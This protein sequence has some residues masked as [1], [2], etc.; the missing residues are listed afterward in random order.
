MVQRSHFHTFLFI[1]KT[2]FFFFFF[3][4]VCS[5]HGLALKHHLKTSSRNGSL[6]IC[7]RKYC[8]DGIS[9]GPLEPRASP[10]HLSVFY[11]YMT[12]ISVKE[13]K[14]K[15]DFYPS[16]KKERNVLSVLGLQNEDKRI[17]SFSPTHNNGV[18]NLYFWD[19]VWA[20]RLYCPLS[21]CAGSAVLYSGAM[22]Q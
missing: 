15:K 13:K 5:C 16:K 11:Y 17:S 1:T 20:C 9:H 10:I 7:S 3:L 21:S 19:H 18:F 6:N 14:K 2:I 8:T 12:D 22:F 4:Q